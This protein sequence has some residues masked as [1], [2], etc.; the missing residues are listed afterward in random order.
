MA[1]AFVSAVAVAVCLGGYQYA[2]SQVRWAAAMQATGSLSRARGATCKCGASSLH[3]RAPA[4]AVAVGAKNRA[5]RTQTQLT[6]ST[7]PAG[8]TSG[9]VPCRLLAGRREG[10]SRSGEA[11]ALHLF[12]LTTGSQP[13]L[14]HPGRDQLHPYS[15][16]QL[17]QDLKSELQSLRQARSQHISQITPVQTAPVQTAAPSVSTPAKRDTEPQAA[18][19]VRV[20]CITHRACQYTQHIERMAVLFDERTHAYSH[21]SMYPCITTPQGAS[22][23]AGKEAPCTL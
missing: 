10:T 14:T 9:C 17:L 11:A 4:G 16:V 23:P 7:Q 19:K 3:L 18:P 2:N 20:P 21:V 15:Q 12:P 6:G 22:S 5:A 1:I 13:P 8:S